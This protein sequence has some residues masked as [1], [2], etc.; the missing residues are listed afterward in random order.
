MILEKPDKLRAQKVGCFP[1]PDKLYC[2]QD[3]NFHL[4][5]IDALFGV[6]I[7]TWSDK[8]KIKMHFFLHLLIIKQHDCSYIKCCIALISILVPSHIFSSRPWPLLKGEEYHDFEYFF[9]CHVL[10]LTFRRSSE[11][12]HLDRS[13]L[14]EMPNDAIHSEQNAHFLTLKKS[15]KNF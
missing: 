5:K 2:L 7:C 14:H 1:M 6:K 9:S 8:D 15:A 12:Q 10:D 3:N 11:S 13:L 4:G